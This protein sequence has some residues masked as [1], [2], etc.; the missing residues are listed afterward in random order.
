MKTITDQFDA[1][2]EHQDFKKRSW[3]EANRPLLQL[4]FNIVAL[5]A[6]NSLMVD[7]WR[8]VTGH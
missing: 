2:I 8:S 6:A 4:A 1:I 3:V 7:I 5:F